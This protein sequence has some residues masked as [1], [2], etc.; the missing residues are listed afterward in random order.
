MFSVIGIV[1]EL[2]VECTYP[3]DQA[4]SQTLLDF[5]SR[6]QL[7]FLMAF[8]YILYRPLSEV[9]LENQIC[10]DKRDTSHELAKDY[11]PY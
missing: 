8:E 3:I 4:L 11:L 1:N 7:P 9:E 5:S 10:S 2:I 6:I